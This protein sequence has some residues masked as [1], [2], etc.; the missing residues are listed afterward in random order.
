[1]AGVKK[2]SLVYNI[3]LQLYPLSDDSCKEARKSDDNAAFSTPKAHFKIS[4]V[5][6]SPIENSDVNVDKSL[7]T[8]EEDCDNTSPITK[9]HRREV[10]EDQRGIQGW[11][12]L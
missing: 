3:E 12:V 7:K 8:E 2:K 11:A 9:G 1:M 4:D 10:V 5:L 6:M